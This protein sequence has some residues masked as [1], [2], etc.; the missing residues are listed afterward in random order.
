VMSRVRDLFSE[1]E[2]SFIA[3]GFVF[4]AIIVLVASRDD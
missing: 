4:S 1:F 2:V 3:C